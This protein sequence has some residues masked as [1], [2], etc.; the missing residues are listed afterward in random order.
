[1]PD[2]VVNIVAV[3]GS[4]KE[5]QRLI[6]QCFRPKR[7]SEEGDIH[8]D[9][10]TLIP[11]GTPRSVS[12]RGEVHLLDDRAEKWGT[13]WNAFGSYIVSQTTRRFEFGFNTAW[14]APE[15]VYRQL[16]REFPALKF[17][18]TA[19]EFGQFRAIEVIVAADS[20]TFKEA[21]FEKTYEKVFKEPFDD[22]PNT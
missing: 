4:Q 13:K 17:N 22:E 12:I 10:E 6:S 21:D 14:A 20:V 19:I 18:I 8:F 11:L 3:T 15:P 1:M 7:P 9:F 2:E 5:I 16:G